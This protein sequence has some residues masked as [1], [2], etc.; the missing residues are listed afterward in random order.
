M[1]QLLFFHNLHCLIQ[2][3]PSADYS[4]PPRK[5]PKSEISSTT[6]FLSFKL[7]LNPQLIQNKSRFKLKKSSHQPTHLPHMVRFRS[8]W[9]SHPVITTPP[10]QPQKSANPGSFISADK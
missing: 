4:R 10:L 1:F 5:I 8:Q 9:K 3:Y 6:I 2:S 7:P